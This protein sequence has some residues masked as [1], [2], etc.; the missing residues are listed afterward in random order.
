MGS[1]VAN[2]LRN[3]LDD[4][5]AVGIVSFSSAAT[6]LAD[7]TV[8]RGES[9]RDA[10]INAVPIKAAGGTSIGAGIQECAQVSCLTYSNYRV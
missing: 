7:M 1:A 10:L 4:G 9:S 6:V 2:Y 8:I 5:T 3:Y